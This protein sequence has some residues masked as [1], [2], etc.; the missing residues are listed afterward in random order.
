LQQPAEQ[1]AAFIQNLGL[2]DG[3]IV[4]IEKSTI[5]ILH[6]PAP[7]PIQRTLR[8]SLGVS[9]APIS[10][11]IAW[12]VRVGS[13]YLQ[14][15]IVNVIVHVHPRAQLL[16]DGLVQ[17][18]LPLQVIE[19]L[20]VSICL[21]LF[22]DA[23][24]ALVFQDSQVLLIHAV[25]LHEVA[26]VITFHQVVHAPILAVQ[27]HHHR[28]LCLRVQADLCCQALHHGIAHHRP[29]PVLPTVAQDQHVI[30]GFQVLRRILALEKV[31]L[32]GIALSIIHVGIQAQGFLGIVARPFAVQADVGLLG[33]AEAAVRLEIFKIGWP[34]PLLPARLVVLLD[35]NAD[36]RVKQK[37]RVAHQ[38]NHRQAVTA[39]HVFADKIGARDHRAVGAAVS[40]NRSGSDDRRLAHLA[41]GFNPV[42][43]VAGDHRERV[44]EAHEA[45][46]GQGAAVEVRL[47]G[48][49]GTVSGVIHTHALV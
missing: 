45:A 48:G 30:T 38:R 6:Q 17:R 36:L 20:V 1:E 29:A 13:E 33:V 25:V 11:V 42:T 23:Q 4:F 7:A 41:L 21:R 28:P 49:H 47:L 43:G 19:H 46:D 18:G 8:P 9:H 35:V 32:K 26:S 3:I 12:P 40:V 14:N 27:K 31:I 15:L 34:L 24:H 44:G 16:V 2:P 22:A 10:D 37:L 5:G 39:Q